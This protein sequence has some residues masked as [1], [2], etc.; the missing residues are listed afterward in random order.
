MILS[1]YEVPI[2]NI[3][4]YENIGWIYYFTNPGTVNIYDSN[5]ELLISDVSANSYTYNYTDGFRPV[6][7]VRDII[8]FPPTLH[9]INTVVDNNVR[10]DIFR[11]IETK[12]SYINILDDDPDEIIYHT[13]TDDNEKK[14]LINT[15][16][17]DNYITTTRIDNLCNKTV[18]PISYKM[19]IDN[20]DSET[21]DIGYVIKYTDNDY[22]YF[23]IY[24]T[25]NGELTIEV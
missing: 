18:T 2:T 17:P 20:I 19:S 23:E 7:Y 13:I 14:I 22:N 16:D 25:E 4:K 10:M 15:N 12:V 3:T 5:F 6:S 9:I 21:V 8:D 24:S 1:N 11:N